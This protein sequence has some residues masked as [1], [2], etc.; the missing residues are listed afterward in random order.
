VLHSLIEVKTLGLTAFPAKV[1]SNQLLPDVSRLQSIRAEEWR[2][3][4]ARL[5]NIGL[6][7]EYVG[8]ITKVGEQL[9]DIASPPLRNW[10]ARRMSD[11][12]AYAMR[13][14]MLDDAVTFQEA[15]LALGKILLDKLI[16]AG[17]VLSRED[18]KLVS[19]F[20]MVVGN[21]LYILCDDLVIGE[22]AVMGAGDTTNTL[23][24][25]SYPR[26]SIENMLDLGCG[27]GSC[28]LLFAHMA[29]RVLA[30]DINPRAIALSRLNAT[31]NGI[32]NIDFRVGDLFD[33]LEGETFDLIVSQPPYCAL[34]CG[35]ERR[36]FLHGG[37][38]GDEL[39]LKVLS[40]VA[41]HLRPG[42]RAI[43]L[44]EWP[45]IQG[46]S[47][48]ERI[49]SAVPS[50]DA[51]I[52][53]LKYPTRG[54]DDFCTRYAAIDYPDLGTEFERSAILRREHLESL[55][56]CGLTQTVI[57]VQR[58]SA[59]LRWSGTFEIPA[60]DA[61]WVTSARI[62]KLVAAR[63]LLAA[64]RCQL[65][66][67]CLRVPEGTVF[68]KEYALGKPD[69][70]KFTVHFPHQALGGTMGLSQGAV[71]LVT[72][73]DEAP[74]VNSAVERFAK[75]ELLTLDQ[76]LERLVPGLEE[77]LLTGMLEVA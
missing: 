21:G 71:L 46:Q 42:G 4:K 9:L 50:N 63:D 32:S 36:A 55:A 13:M 66:A 75:Q 27:A 2:Q 33:P 60:Q 37:V 18:R 56:V 38:R 72:L 7:E 47:I 57:V 40:Q 12:A 67:A 24:Q 22:D 17:L 28:A 29:T 34:P 59:G 43:L 1:L 45:E 44:V 5:Q 74:D 68:A 6:T 39:P 23:C 31:M 10:H 69:Q 8:K 49:A 14:L 62:D 3:L 77:A 54:L 26:R 11:S 70:P 25:A 30:T 41:R 51:N 73:V 20:R 15:E 61:D 76:A 65:L 19:P 52:L 48:E 16:E 53:I 64:G 58:N 35:V